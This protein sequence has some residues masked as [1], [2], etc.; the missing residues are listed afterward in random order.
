MKL[1]ILENQ[2][3]LVD[4]VKQLS[5]SKG[6][7]YFCSTMVNSSIANINDEIYDTDDVQNTDSM[8]NDLCD[9]PQTSSFSIDATKSASFSNEPACDYEARKKA[10]QRK[11]V[12]LTSILTKLNDLAKVDK[13]NIIKDSLNAS[14]TDVNE[15]ISVSSMDTIQEAYLGCGLINYLKSLD[16]HS[17]EKRNQLCSLLYNVYGDDL[18][19]NEA[20]LAWLSKRL[21]SK[22][23]RLR[24]LLNSWLMCESVEN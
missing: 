24:T 9:S 19:V 10:K 21:N 1:H 7:T 5:N 12:T 20:F 22:P 17:P 16:C 3:L 13:V 11:T 15:L 4:I 2:V 14:D 23:Y 8:V 6:K 18:L